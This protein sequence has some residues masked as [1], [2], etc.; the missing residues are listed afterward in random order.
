[1]R[2]ITRYD[3]LHVFAN[4]EHQTATQDDA[5]DVLCPL[6]NKGICLACI[7]R[8]YRQTP[9]DSFPFFCA[10]TQQDLPEEDDIGLPMNPPPGLKPQVPTVTYLRLDAKGKKKFIKECWDLTILRD[11]ALHEPDAKIKLAARKKVK[12]AETRAAGATT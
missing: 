7:H 4:Q 3:T 6:G 11:V 1:M 8:P 9:F 5:V 10:L 2:H 12:A